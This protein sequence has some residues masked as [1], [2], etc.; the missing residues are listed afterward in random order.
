MFIHRK[1]FLLNY[2]EIIF[3]Y[4]QSTILLVSTCKKATKTSVSLKTKYMKDLLAIKLMVRYL[5][6]IL[7]STHDIV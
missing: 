5:Q 3:V 4:L 7:A 6:C 2:S 1:M